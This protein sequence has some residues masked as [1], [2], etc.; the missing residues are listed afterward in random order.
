M[1]RVTIEGTITPSTFLRRGAQITVERTSYIEKLIKRGFVKVV[2]EYP[3][4]KEV[5]QIVEAQR[6]AVDNERQLSGTPARNASRD[7][8]ADFLGDEGVPFEEGATRDELIATWD[9]YFPAEAD[10]EAETDG[11]TE[12]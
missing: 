1:A 10:V 12:D 5:V 7:K 9:S 2:R 6:E 8:W 11:G 3:V 4:E